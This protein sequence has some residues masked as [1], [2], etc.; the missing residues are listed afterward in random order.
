MDLITS[1][2]RM[3]LIAAPLYAA[4][5]SAVIFSGR[6][7]LDLNSKFVDGREVFGKGKTFRGTFFGIITGIIVTLIIANFFFNE[8]LLLT[9]HYVFYGILVSVGAIFGDLTGSFLKRRMGLKR[10]APVII[11][12][13]FDFL[14]VGILFGAFY[15]LPSIEEFIALAAITLIAHKLSNM[16]AFKFKL[17]KVPW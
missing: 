8:T 7:P 3:A 13:Q 14:F 10:G 2:V 6:T 11:L 15:A 16:I 17:K 12:D 9:K 4:N 1:I 5:G